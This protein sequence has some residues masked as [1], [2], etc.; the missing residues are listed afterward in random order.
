[1]SV[2]FFINHRTLFRFDPDS[3]ETAYYDKGR[4]VPSNDPVLL[5]EIRFRTVEIS[6]PD[7]L[8]L[9]RPPVM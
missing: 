3:C 5:H 1:M 9:I 2:K 8:R 7:V 4:W 6:Y